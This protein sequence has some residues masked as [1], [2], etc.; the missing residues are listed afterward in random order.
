MRSAPSSCTPCVEWT[1]LF[2]NAMNTM[3]AAATLPATPDRP[4]HVLRVIASPRGD[5]SESRRL[6]QEILETL[7][8]QAGGRTLHTTD[9]DT[10]E[11][12][13]V[14]GGYAAALASPADPKS[15]PDQG[16]ALHRSDRL[17]AQLD[18]ADVVV[19]ATPMHNFT[20][21][22]ALKAWV[23]HIVRIRATFSVTPQGKVGTLRNR[24][25]YVAISCGGFISGERAR[26]PDF[27]RP[28][29]QHTLGTVGLHD[30]HF[31]SVEGTALGEAALQAGRQ[32]ASEAVAAL[33]APHDS[34]LRTA[35]NGTP[36]DRHHEAESALA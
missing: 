2:Y 18:A 1:H 29:L 16:T 17:I 34:C 26:Q 11:L 19:I 27:L 21:P 7:T 15:P 14:D 35:T 23:D 31:I 22:S 30:V 13:A 24:P 3:N 9:L 10:H 8:L 28:Y 20:L 4:V 12:P 36:L 25:V 33:F 6:S 32:R 5:A